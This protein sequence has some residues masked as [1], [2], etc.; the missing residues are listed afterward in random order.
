MDQDLLLLSML[1]AG[2]A[3]CTVVIQDNGG[4]LI[5]LFLAGLLGS[6]THCLS[7]CAPFVLSQVTARLETIPLEKMS[8]FRRLSGA[9]LLPYHFGRMTTYIILGLCAG[10]LAQGAIEFSGMKWISSVL[11]MLAAVFFLGYALKRL[12]LSFPNM[13]FF[14]S[15]QNSEGLF[16]KTFTG[17]LKPL[18]AQ[19]TGIN[20]YFLGLGLGFLPCGLLYGALAA[21]GSSGDFV[22]GAMGMGVFAL[23]TVPSLIGVGLA[24]H[25]AGQK[26]REVISDLA[27][28]L[29][30]I[31]AGI[32]A[33]LAWSL[34]A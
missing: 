17:L 19:P 29:L 31:N 12:G 8:E 2:L 16:S 18:F 14:G 27:P 4:L 10:L 26:W 33:Y 24:G 28:I 9:A 34:I 15:S 20:G 6:A 5:S 21:A 11:L 22:T 13:L 32:L 23:G 30:I 25:M 3:H 1:D 7:M